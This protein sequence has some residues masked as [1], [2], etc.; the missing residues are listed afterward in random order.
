[1]YKMFLKEY[2][3]KH[4]GDYLGRANGVVGNR[5]RGKLVFYCLPFYIFS[6]RKSK[7]FP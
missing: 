7:L 6:K 2:T 4:D 1:M 5:V 3:T